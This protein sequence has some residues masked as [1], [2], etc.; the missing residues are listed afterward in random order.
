[1][2]RRG[3]EHEEVVVREGDL[4]RVVRTHAVH[5]GIGRPGLT[6]PLQMALEASPP[7]PLKGAVARDEEQGE[8][9][10]D[11]RSDFRGFHE[12]AGEIV[13]DRGVHSVAKRE[14]VLLWDGKEGLVET[15]GGKSVVDVLFEQLKGRVQAKGTRSDGGVMKKAALDSQGIEFVLEVRKGREGAVES[16]ERVFK[17]GGHVDVVETR[18]TG[19]VKLGRAEGSKG[20]DAVH[21]GESGP[22]GRVGGV[23]V[24]LD[25]GPKGGSGVVDKSPELQWVRGQPR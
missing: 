5:A 9:D 18:E 15:D 2:S 23:D 22:D 1:M 17:V 13:D 6:S 21:G 24:G 4:G 20:I 16:D 8:Q 14:G 12:V 3:L 11:E 19:D 10:Q 7:V 25:G